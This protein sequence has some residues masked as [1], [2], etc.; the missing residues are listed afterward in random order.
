MVEILALGGLTALGVSLAA[1]RSRRR[2]LVSRYTRFAL[3]EHLVLPWILLAVLG[4]AAYLFPVLLSLSGTEFVELMQ[5]QLVLGAAMSILISPLAIVLLVILLAPA[6][7]ALHV[8]AH[9][10][11][12]FVLKAM[13]CLLG[14]SAVGNIVGF[15]LGRR[16]LMALS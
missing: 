6:Y 11:T 4:Y 12:L 5:Y 3:F 9:V 7:L 13:W 1:F 2:F 16:S 15:A 14:A 8:E 10:I